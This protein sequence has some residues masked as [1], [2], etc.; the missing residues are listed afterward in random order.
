MALSTTN[1][2]GAAATEGY[3][4]LLKNSGFNT[5]DYTGDE[6]GQAPVIIF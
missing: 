4:Y 6:P 2:A 3:T 5:A 1:L